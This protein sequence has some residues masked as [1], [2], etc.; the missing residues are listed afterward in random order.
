LSICPYCC[1]CRVAKAV[2]CY[3]HSSCA[4]RTVASSRSRRVLAAS[5]SSSSHS[6]PCEKVL[7]DW[8]NVSLAATSL[9]ALLRMRSSSSDCAF[10][11]ASSLSCHRSFARA[12]SAYRA[13]RESRFGSDPRTALSRRIASSDASSAATIVAPTSDCSDPSLPLQPSTCLATFCS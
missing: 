13:A 7:H 8:R 11:S 10:S 4:A 3:R 2:A 5:L 12:S 1:Y 6:P 9:S